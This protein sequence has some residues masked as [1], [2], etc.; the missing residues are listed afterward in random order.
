MSPTP[1]QGAAAIAAE[2]A[3]ALSR[4][5]SFCQELEVVADCLPGDVDAAK[6]AEIADRIVPVI[7][8]AHAFEDGVVFVSLDRISAG[9]G[10]RLGPILR[11]LRH[12]HMEDEGYA[13]EIA[14]ILAAYASGAPGAAAEA[15]GYMLRGFFASKRR[16]IAYERDNILPLLAAGANR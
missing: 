16:H 7:R 2:F 5:E 3:A 14:E 15:I 4:L 12:E 13:E 10:G 6:I 8:A 1:T 9:E 11:R